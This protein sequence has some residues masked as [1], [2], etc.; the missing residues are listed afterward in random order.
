MRQL[1][2]SKT[3]KKISIRVKQSMNPKIS[4]KSLIIGVANIFLK[5]KKQTSRFKKINFY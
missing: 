1:A 2:L 5:T 4:A 3:I